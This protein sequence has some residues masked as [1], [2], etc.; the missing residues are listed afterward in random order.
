MEEDSVQ[1][2]HSWALARDLL[3]AEAGLCGALE[4]GGGSLHHSPGPA[5]RQ[6]GH[7][8]SAFRSNCGSQRRMPWS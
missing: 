8:L 2:D 4:P 1:L 7:A 6:A 5:G 3:V